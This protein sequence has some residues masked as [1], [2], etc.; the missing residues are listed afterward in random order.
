M[1]SIFK[2]KQQQ[3]HD[4]NSKENSE[5]KSESQMGFD[6]TTFRDLVG[7]SNIMLFFHLYCTHFG[8]WIAAS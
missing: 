7:C 6:P 5:Q 8:G 3:Q 2:T 1:K 4:I